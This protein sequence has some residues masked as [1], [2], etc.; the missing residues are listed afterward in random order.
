MDGTLHPI[1]FFENSL[2]K[3]QTRFEF[4]IEAGFS[5][6]QTQASFDKLP[7][8]TVFYLLR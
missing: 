8:I 5:D 3:G 1:S 4:T 6:A 2:L 7:K